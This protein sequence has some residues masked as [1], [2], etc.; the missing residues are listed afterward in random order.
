MS[1]A[2]L[3]GP[4]TSSP[5]LQPTPPPKKTPPIQ[6]PRLTLFDESLPEDLDDISSFSNPPMTAASPKELNQ[7]PISL[8]EYSE[9]IWPLSLLS[10]KAPL[11]RNGSIAFYK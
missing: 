8:R 2:I 6:K 4:S 3:T 9:S 7:N 1:G 11:S 5:F 10:Q